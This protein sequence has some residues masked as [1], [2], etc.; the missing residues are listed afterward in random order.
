MTFPYAG[1]TGNSL[2]LVERSFAVDGVTC[3]V[4]S[5]AAQLGSPAEYKELPLWVSRDID[6]DGALPCWTG[7]NRVFAQT[8]EQMAAHEAAES[9]FR[10][11]PIFLLNAR[12]LD[13]PNGIA[14]LLQMMVRTYEVPL[15]E[16]K[17]VVTIAAEAIGVRV[18][19]EEVFGQTFQLAA[20]AIKNAGESSKQKALGNA[21]AQLALMQAQAAADEEDPS[22][23]AAAPRGAAFV[24][25]DAERTQPSASS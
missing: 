1:S 4:L 14:R 12:W 21:R 17:R 20:A 23:S 9:V 19:E 8:E 6:D 22:A 15:E 5:R 18:A 7:V 25:D 3:R 16:A 11:E 24:E 2:E 10:D 13:S